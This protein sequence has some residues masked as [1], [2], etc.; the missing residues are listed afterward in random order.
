[1]PETN[2][3]E[4]R[5][6]LIIKLNHPPSLTANRAADK[7]ENANQNSHIPDKSSEGKFFKFSKILSCSTHFTHHLIQN[8]LESSNKSS[9]RSHHN[10]TNGSQKWQ[11]TISNSFDKLVKLAHQLEPTA[12]EE[13]EVS[14]PESSI[15]QTSKRKRS[16]KSLPVSDNKSSP[17]TPPSQSLCSSNSSER[18]PT[19]ATPP[20]LT[21]M[22]EACVSEVNSEIKKIVPDN[23]SQINRVETPSSVSTETSS[24]ADSLEDLK[25]KKVSR[26]PKKNVSN[27]VWMDSNNYYNQS[28][29]NINNHLFNLLNNQHHSSGILQM[30][31]QPPVPASNIDPTS[32]APYRHVNPGRNDRY[33]HF[34]G[35]PSIGPYS[36]NHSVIQSNKT[37]DLLV[38][39]T[40][41]KLFSFP[42][43]FNQQ[44][45][46][47]TRCKSIVHN[48]LP[49]FN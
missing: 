43:P 47:G 41:E 31:K 35:Q 32:Y 4:K 26:P 10:T 15:K 30:N 20:T 5:T 29:I 39:K 17:D 48:F 7:S 21:P 45:P 24:T 9:V 1:M 14:L 49:H 37:T 23:L 42:P 11:A 16:H 44:H 34:E 3:T 12:R 40:C 6:S 28:A 27:G 36:Q 8:Y 25:V 19:P 2:E 38:S 46:G 13:S 33:H 18:P 22:P